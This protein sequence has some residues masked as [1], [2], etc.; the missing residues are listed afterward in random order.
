MAQ[1]TH[2]RASFLFLALLQF[3]FFIFA[4][5]K[6]EAQT[7]GH[8]QGWCELGGHRDAQ[9]GDFVHASYP[10][11]T[12]D[13]YFTG[14]TTRATIYSD[15]N[16]TPLQNPF[17]AASNGSIEFYAPPGTFY[18]IVT[19]GAGMPTPF[20]YSYVTTS[21]PG[22]SGGIL[23][24]PSSPQTI[25]GQMLTLTP[26]APLMVNGATLLTET[27]TKSLNNVK[28]ADRFAGTDAC[29]KIHAA[30]IALP[31]GGG[32]VD[33]RGFHGVQ[34]CSSDPFSNASTPP[35]QLLIGAATFQLTA[36]WNLSIGTKITCLDPY[37]STIM[38]ATN[39]ATWVVTYSDTAIENC[40]V[41]GGL[42]GRGSRITVRSNTIE[43]SPAGANINAAGNP[44]YWLIQGNIIRNGG[45]E[46][47]L[48]NT[49]SNAVPDDP[50]CPSGS[51]C[52]YN[53]IVDNWI[54]GNRKNAIDMNSGRNTI[55]GNHV[56]MNGGRGHTEGGMDQFGILLFSAG[57]P[58][59]SETPVSHNIVSQNEVF[60][61][62]TFGIALI[63]G[64]GGT[65]A[66]NIV[67]DNSVRYNGTTASAG[68]ADGIY[69]EA[70]GSGSV[71]NNVVSNNIVIGNTRN[72]IFLNFPVVGSGSMLSNQ[73]I[74]NQLLSNTQYG[75]VTDGGVSSAGG[76]AVF[77]NY[78]VN[79]VALG[80]GVGQIGDFGS[81]RAIYSNK[82]STT[83]LFDVATSVF[84][85]VTPTS[86]FTV[87][88]TGIANDTAG[89]KHARF[90]S[91]CTAASGAT[92]ASTY[93]WTTRFADTNYTVTC[94]LAGTITGTPV[95][96]A[97]SSK[98]QSGIT[99]TIANAG[100]SSASASEVDCIAV[101]D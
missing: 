76:H 15:L 48:F 68:A 43:G 65:T 83:Q 85:D 63:A 35:V 39:T 11:C 28:F 61:N 62:N 58:P 32:V 75:F 70:Y 41:V 23:A 20:T 22:A 67:T 90:G 30:I 34:A 93:Y 19:S 88:M 12:V 53:Q 18:D 1:Y 29:S 95:I 27:S 24:S 96:R 42:I 7:L 81:Q 99:I 4:S 66:Y 57:G 25:T 52:G 10:S 98:L 31:S 74:G 78:V 17:T 56:F 79:N 3:S 55:R 21:G 26:S 9:T 82:K 5:V 94:S 71:L 73:F 59:V 14:T 37:Q 91:S 87:S 47:I 69:L 45:N 36:Q 8:W 80:N 40:H 33:A 86:M 101:H 38:G 6:S 60:S 64:P 54:Y 44:T 92:C 77:D 50:N 72:G 97:I 2:P 16:S 51:N 46:G 49:N 89:L 100:R 13:V 84:G